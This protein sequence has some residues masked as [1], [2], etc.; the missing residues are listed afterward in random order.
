MNGEKNLNILL[1]SIDP[2]LN[3][4]EYVF[5]CI[6]DL[7][8]LDFGWIV[9][10]I[11]EKEGLSVI[12]SRQK[13]DE[14]GFRYSFVSAWITL[15][16][17][18]ALDAVGL[19]AAFSAVLASKGISCNVLAGVHHDHIFVGIEDAERA[20]EALKELSSI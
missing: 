19:T 5:C 13:A 18:S 12:L 6:Q 4:G 17:H 7:S 16:V 14:Q 1:K 2:V 9:G 11:R 20:M 3:E 10:S 15:N 8:G